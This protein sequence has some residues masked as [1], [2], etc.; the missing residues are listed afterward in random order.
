MIL[1]LDVLSLKHDL[2]EPALELAR[3]CTDV[4]LLLV[5]VNR[6]GGGG[7]VEEEEEERR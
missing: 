6:E 4:V 1:L 2:G 5:M 3:A 7:E